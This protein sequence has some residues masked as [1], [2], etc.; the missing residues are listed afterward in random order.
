MTSRI[1]TL[2]A[3]AGLAVA[4]LAAAAP[5]TAAWRVVGPGMAVADARSGNASL[6]AEC[7][8]DGLVLGIYNI[9]WE[10]DH[11]EE[12]DLVV[13]GRSFTL[14]QYG[15]GDRIV[16]SDA[17][18]AGG[19]LDISPDLRSA[20]K[21]GSQ[22]RLEGPAVGHIDPKLITFSLIRSENAINTVERFC[23]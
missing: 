2:A 20:L 15:S 21:A 22:A 11:A 3:A 6:A 9:V 19:N 4:G 23:E 12:L 7:L 10:F 5:A 13:D 17:D 16:F 1:V 8:Q 18:S 14:H